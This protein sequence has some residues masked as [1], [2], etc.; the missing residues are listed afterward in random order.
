MNEILDKLKPEFLH[1]LNSQCATY[2][3]IG[4]GVG[5]YSYLNS[6]E[7][8]KWFQYCNSDIYRPDKDEN[9]IYFMSSQVN[10]MYF[11]VSLDVLT[12]EEKEIVRHGRF[13]EVYAYFKSLKYAFINENYPTITEG[14][15]Q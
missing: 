6:A 5:E 11:Y 14:G 1:H 7:S 9:T 8:P 4:G 2:C 13:N 12:E 10:Y 3:T 15:T